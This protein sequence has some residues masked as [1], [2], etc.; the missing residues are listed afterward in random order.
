MKKSLTFKNH[1]QE[2]LINNTAHSPFIGNPFMERKEEFK[3][4]IPN[5]THINLYY[6]FLKVAY[7]F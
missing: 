4:K 5:K 3:L 1:F 2:S 6:K 7:G